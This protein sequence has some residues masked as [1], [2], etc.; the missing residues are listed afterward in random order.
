MGDLMLKL[1]RSDEAAPY[2][3]KSF[4]ISKRLADKEPRRSDFLFELVESYTKMGDLEIALG[5]SEKGR[6]FY[7][8]ALRLAERLAGNEPGRTDY[9]RARAVLLERVRDPQNTVSAR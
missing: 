6:Q 9:Q 7:R 5:K 4:A 3:E 1:G 8:D 2:Y